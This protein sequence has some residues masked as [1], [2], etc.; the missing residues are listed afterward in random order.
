MVYELIAEVALL[1][2]ECSNWFFQLLD[3]VG[4][5]AYYMG[6]VFVAI[7]SGFLLSRFGSGRVTGSDTAAQTI[8]SATYRGKYREGAKRNP[9]GQKGRYERK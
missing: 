7:V 9:V 4:G 1:I 6:A 5:R 2:A 3:A 8:K